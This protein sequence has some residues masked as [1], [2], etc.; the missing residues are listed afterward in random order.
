[1]APLGF[2]DRDLMDLRA[3]RRERGALVAWEEIFR[4][5]LLDVKPAK[6]SSSQPK[7]IQL[8][9]E[10]AAGVWL[11][12]FVG[13][14]A[15]EHADRRGKPTSSA[16]LLWDM[17]REAILDKGSS[18]FWN[19]LDQIEDIL[20]DFVD[21]SGLYP[22]LVHK[23]QIK[24][25]IASTLEIL[26][27]VDS[28]RTESGRPRTCVVEHLYRAVAALE[29]LWNSGDADPGVSPTY[30]R[31]ISV[32]FSEAGFLAGCQ[33]E[34]WKQ[35]AVASVTAALAEIQLQRRL[36]AAEPDL[37]VAVAMVQ[38]AVTWLLGF[39]LSGPEARTPILLVGHAQDGTEVR[40]TRA[41]LVV[42]CLER[43]DGTAFSPDPIS[44]GWI[45][46]DRACRA[47]FERAHQYVRWKTEREEGPDEAA[48]SW[49]V[50]FPCTPD[51]DEGTMD[52][53][54]QHP[55]HPWLVGDS[56]S[57]AAAC[58]L[59]AL[60]AGDALDPGTC[61]MASLRANGARLDKGGLQE[62]GARLAKIQV[63]DAA[64]A[65]AGQAAGRAAE[66]FG[67]LL[68]QL[69]EVE[70]V[71]TVSPSAQLIDT[72]KRNCIRVQ[73]VKTVDAAFDLMSRRYAAIRDFL[74]R[75][76]HQALVRHLLFFPPNWD[77][78]EYHEF[79][80]PAMA[81]SEEDWNELSGARRATDRLT[82]PMLEDQGYLPPSS[83]LLLK[84]EGERR[85]IAPQPLS[86]TIAGGTGSWLLQG[87]PG[88]G[89]TV[90]LWVDLA[91]RCRD[92]A[93]SMKSG[94]LSP[95]APECLVPLGFPLGDLPSPA[96]WK[97]GYA[98]GIH[99]QA[100]YS[101]LG[102]ARREALQ[103]AYGD[104]EQPEWVVDWLDDKIRRR[105]VR[106]YLDALDE[107]AS[108]EQTETGESFR[109]LRS[110]V[111]WLQEQFADLARAGL[112]PLLITSRYTGAGRLPDIPVQTD[113]LR[114]AAFGQREV[115]QYVDRYFARLED[116]DQLAAELKRRLRQSPGPKALARLPLLLAIICESW[117]DQAEQASEPILPRSKTGLLK[118][119][120]QGMMR[121]GDQRRRHKHERAGRNELKER[122]L[123][124]VAW[125][126]YTTEPLEFD[127]AAFREA[128]RPVLRS[129]QDHYKE[130]SLPDNPD[131]LL[132]ELKDDGILVSKAGGLGFVLRSFHELCLAG[133][134]ACECPDA[135]GGD[136]EAFVAMIRGRAGQWGRRE[137]WG[138]IKPLNQPG[139]EYVWPLIGAQMRDRADYL[140]EALWKEHME[141]EDIG[142]SRLRLAAA[143]AAEMPDSPSSLYRVAVIQELA[144]LYGGVERC[145]PDFAEALTRIPE[146]HALSPLW[147]YRNL[148]ARE[149]IRRHPDR[150]ARESC[151]R[152]RGPT[153]EGEEL[154]AIVGN[155]LRK[156]RY[157]YLPE[158]EPHDLL[159]NRLAAPDAP[160]WIANQMCILSLG[161][162][163]EYGRLSVRRS[164][165]APTHEDSAEGLMAV[166]G[167]EASRG[168][169]VSRLADP[170]GPP[171]HYK[172]LTGILFSTDRQTLREPME[173]WLR[174]PCVPEAVHRFCV[175]TLAK[176]VVWNAWCALADHL[177]DS[178]ASLASRC[179]CAVALATHKGR[180]ARETLVRCLND[181]E[182]PQI[183]RGAC[184]T[185]L[186]RIG[187]AECRDALI[188]TLNSS[189]ASE[190][191]RVLSAHALGT[192]GDEL[193]KDAL[194][195]VYREQARSGS[196]WIRGFCARALVELGRDPFPAMPL[197]ILHGSE[198]G[199]DPSPT[200]PLPILHGLESK[201]HYL[202][203]IPETLGAIKDD[204]VWESLVQTLSDRNAP[205]LLRSSC[206]TSLA[207]FGDDPSQDA[208]IGQL[209]DE[210]DN[211]LIGA[212]SAEALAAFGDETSRAVLI[213][214]LLDAKA[215]PSAR[216][217]CAR[218]LGEIGGSDAREAL[219]S[220]FRTLSKEHYESYHSPD[221]VIVEALARVADVNLRDSIIRQISDSAM[222][223]LECEWLA[224]LLGKIGDPKSCRA[225]IA[226]LNDS[227]S[228]F[229]V[230]LACIA[231]LSEIPMRE[232]SEALLDML[233]APDTDQNLRIACV[234]YSS[235]V[236][237]E[238]TVPTLIDILNDSPGA[239][240]PEHP[241]AISNTYRCTAAAI[242][243]KIG[244]EQAKKSLMFGLNNSEVPEDV[245][246]KCAVGLGHI[247]GA[248]VQEH[249][250]RIFEDPKTP[251]KVQARCA[252]V[253][254]RMGKTHARQAVISCL[255]SSYRES[256]GELKPAK[257]LAAFGDEISLDALIRA[258]WTR[259]GRPAGGLDVLATLDHPRAREFLM[260]RFMETC[261]RSSANAVFDG[262]DSEDRDEFASALD[263][264]RKRTGWRALHDE[265][266]D[267]P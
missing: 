263:S 228:S 113:V 133:Y 19:E 174:D 160:E 165:K 50:Q 12:H 181:S 227:G 248:D 34:E 175:E 204:F 21:H 239:I 63:A 162:I 243:G 42:R 109:G 153:D 182:S 106:L 172:W 83:E 250:R 258:C 216:D 96:D 163:S 48:F 32:D 11:D 213:T 207:S 219:L 209:S 180:Q 103:L 157:H 13:R 122:L 130:E 255:E 147:R 170:D 51:L 161:E 237:D 229:V 108:S 168:R 127:P 57:G 49:Y 152:P 45:L 76:A 190:V 246:A 188:A 234:F 131:I 124:H 15:D 194:I 141:L 78:T 230:R 115:H 87:E 85:T 97:R 201:K 36:D 47:S 185:A 240:A 72:G 260:R 86:F 20:I 156:I 71:L 120:I 211:E 74:D 121:R 238:R 107:L 256:Y 266:W 173:E 143:V 138:D 226:R 183:L 267:P 169:L 75:L 1:M 247:D 30:D 8:A 253:L 40:G 28:L 264:V 81:I 212:A 259:F 179:G 232:A 14:H 193:S 54:G 171:Q 217:S 142:F 62:V 10:L 102:W 53:S 251:Q 128:V 221:D 110:R 61:L 149:W 177:G 9:L 225:L 37:S 99:D 58:C 222:P 139:W 198:L 200:M 186:G 94:R 189:K 257:I 244:G 231:A 77:A 24:L 88:E 6:L 144:E 2:H 41:T 111:D 140:L 84:V 223:E 126:F 145:F 92:M 224:D 18:S 206:A 197:P 105:E 202:S 220:A 64:R 66:S 205:L 17:G 29:C 118:L 249:L 33:R 73:E 52:R 137:D 233:E 91:K 82:D 136:R 89:K 35:Q 214:H 254:G 187:D 155:W 129:L 27:A 5:R 235:R 203:W 134:V 191:L 252:L 25:P 23:A 192:V 132:A 56:A 199:R 262:R 148:A 79:C 112:P 67:E 93:A 164:E 184:V 158:K 117:R 176:G 151:E 39:D 104:V 116:G 4:S 38:Q 80:L 46:L 146:V 135:Q 3:T 69:T 16:C 195:R 100:S 43:T 59:L 210:T 215:G 44:L 119:G 60:H 123:R 154:P 241:T 7:E 90:A 95:D 218:A 26:R 150:L 178:D 65:M 125:E 265:T 68:P 101:L 208:L 22:A 114:M 196:N 167:E 261:F 31:P 98:T 236:R 245:R 166:L 242:L 70:T 159:A 55:R